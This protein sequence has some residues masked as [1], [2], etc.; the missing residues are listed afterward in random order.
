MVRSS[1]T[2]STRSGAWNSPRSTGGVAASA[3]GSKSPTGRTGSM[4]KYAAGSVAASALDAIAATADN[5]SRIRVCMPC[6]SSGVVRQTLQNDDRRGQ[7]IA[8]VARELRQR[9]AEHAHA[10]VAPALHEAHAG[11]SGGDAELAPVER[12]L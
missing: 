6:S 1:E 7:Q 10:A 5:N 11:R 12:I 4:W 3:S 9:G 8:F 2:I